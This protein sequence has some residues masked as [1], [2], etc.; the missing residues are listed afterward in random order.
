MHKPLEEKEL[1]IRADI[2]YV[3][4]NHEFYFSIEDIAMEIKEDLSDVKGIT[5]PI[6][7][8]YIEVATI[9]DIEKGR[10][11]KTQEELSEF[12]QALL[13]ARNFKEDKKK[14]KEN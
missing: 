6:N 1:I 14:N 9:A 7:E 4:F 11:K 13:K 5:L 3:Q 2:R 8:K 12:N 10:K